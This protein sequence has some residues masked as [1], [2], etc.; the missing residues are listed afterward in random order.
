MAKSIWISQN[1]GNLISFIPSS[2]FSIHSENTSKVFN[3]IINA[4]CEGN[5]AAFAKIFSL[6]KNTVWMW[7]KGKRIP[8]LRMILT[9]CYCLDISLL[10]FITLKQQAFQ[11][12]RINPQRLSTS[13]RFTR[14]SPRAFDYMATEK[15]L[16]NFLNSTERFLKMKEVA[17]RLKIDRRIIYSYFPNLCKA[18]SAKYRSYQKQQTAERIQKCC[19]EVEQAVRSLHQVGE[20]PSEARVSTLI[21]QPGYF[22][23]KEVRR[24]LNQ[25]TLELGI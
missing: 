15:Y 18:I 6:P 23:Y 11:S 21:S 4:T 19:Q 20:Y 22:R 24:F 12:P 1:L 2:L 9:V 8:E 13:L 3:L 17:R 5:I 10:D 16:Q 14:I 7:C 25:A